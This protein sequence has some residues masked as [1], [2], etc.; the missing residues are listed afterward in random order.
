VGYLLPLFALP[1]FSPPAIVTSDSG[2]LSEDVA[3]L[4]KNVVT[5]I[6]KCGEGQHSKC[7]TTCSESRILTGGRAALSKTRKGNKK[8]KLNG[9]DIN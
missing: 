4:R 6:G 5:R 8:A 3:Q 1:D 2:R 9:T 7:K